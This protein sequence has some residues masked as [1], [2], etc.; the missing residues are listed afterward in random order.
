MLTQV[1][2]WIFT[3]WGAKRFGASWKGALGALIGLII[4]PFIL[5]P[6]I[7]LIL[8]PIIGAILGELI[9]GRHIK[10]A[11]KAG[12]G[13]IIGNLVAFVFKFGIVCTMIVGF[14]INLYSR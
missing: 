3:Y 12:L 1:L 10:H 11:S 9:G 5:T 6:I 8:G 14:Y 4:C 13:A 2:D 7:G